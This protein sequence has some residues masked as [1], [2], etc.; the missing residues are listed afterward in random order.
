MY[1]KR[2]EKEKGGGGGG[3]SFLECAHCTKRSHVTESGKK[4]VKAP[5]MVLMLCL[6]DPT[7][8]KASK[9]PGT[10]LINLRNEFVSN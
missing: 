4:K 9:S 5:N 6:S 2:K 8:D 3:Q 7:T 10:R 1:T